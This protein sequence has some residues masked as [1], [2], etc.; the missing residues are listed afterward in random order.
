MGDII[1]RI[2]EI[3]F[4]VCRE[5][6]CEDNGGICVMFFC[7]VNS[8]VCKLVIAKTFMEKDV[9]LPRAKKNGN[10]GDL[11]GVMLAHSVTVQ[12]KCNDCNI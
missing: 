8:K 4:E 9:E 1:T 5:L 10:K 6:Y 7:H 11:F 3:S 12:D 2:A